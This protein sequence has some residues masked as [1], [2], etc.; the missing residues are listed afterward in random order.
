[1][2]D[3]EVPREVT[4]EPRSLILLEWSITQMFINLVRYILGHTRCITDM[5]SYLCDVRRTLQ[6][7]CSTVLAI[8]SIARK[9]G[10]P[11]QC[12]HQTTSDL[13]SSRMYVKKEDEGGFWKS[14]QERSAEHHL[15]MS[16]P[17]GGE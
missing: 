1:M 15:T 2:P 8:I 9:A 16:H 12:T 4:G 13:I 6:T 3:R 14:I 7:T 11:G 10:R 17:S 5:D